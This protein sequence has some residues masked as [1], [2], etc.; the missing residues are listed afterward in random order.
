[1]TITQTSADTIS[2]KTKNEL[3]TV[4]DGVTIGSYHISGAGEYDVAA[5]QCEA[6]FLKEATVYMISSEELTVTALTQVDVDVTKLDDAPNSDI[7]V[8]EVRS[9]NKDEDLK[10]ILDVLEPSYLF[11][12]GSGATPELRTKLG[13]PVLDST[14]LKVTRSSLPLEGTSLIPA[15]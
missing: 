11:L 6:R 8:I 4:G 9:D 13:L 1:M 2:I 10:K 14:T 15:S 5:I 7:L 12:T 3:V